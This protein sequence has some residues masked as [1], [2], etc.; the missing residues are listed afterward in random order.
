M[1]LYKPFVIAFIVSVVA[2]IVFMVVHFQ[3]MFS[4]I[5]NAETMKPESPLEVFGMIFT[6]MWIASF[7]LLILSSLTYQILG[8]IMIVKNPNINSTDR[9]LWILGFVM[10]AFITAIIFMALRKSKNL[11]NTEPVIAQNNWPPQNRT[12]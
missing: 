4:F 3:T 2:L 5:K 1:K 6:P 11:T 9:V 10:M 12:Y 7:I 8:V